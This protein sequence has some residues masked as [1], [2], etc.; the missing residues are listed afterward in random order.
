MTFPSTR[1]FAP[2]FHVFLFS[3]SLCPVLPPL[4]WLFLCLS[5]SSTCPRQGQKQNSS[6]LMTG[7][8]A[9]R[10]VFVETEIIFSV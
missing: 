1:R 7:P 2:F 6:L 3:L 8:R 5:S 10:R 4:A 9:M